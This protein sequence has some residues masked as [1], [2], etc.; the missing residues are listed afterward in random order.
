M[1]RCVLLV[2]IVVFV[3]CARTPVANA[4]LYTFSGSSGLSGTFT[5]DETT[6]FTMSNDAFGRYGALVSPLSHISGVF[7]AFT[8][9]GIPS[10]FVTDLFSEC[11]G[12]AQDSWIIRSDITGPSVNALTPAVLNLFVF[13]N[14]DGVTPISLI[15]P[16]PGNLP[17]D[18]Q[19]TFG[20]T[21]HSFITGSLT[22]LRLVPE[23]ATLT[24]FVGGI[25]PM[26]ALSWRRTA[27]RTA[28]KVA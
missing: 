17:F 13:R 7:G 14:A 18:F 3:V 11:C 12:G 27:G 22:T 19:Y 24:L 6:P 25:V 16:A 26:V 20:F 2:A 23:P 8:F 10:L 5:I 4:L 9:T 15:P 1:K 21:D 28:K